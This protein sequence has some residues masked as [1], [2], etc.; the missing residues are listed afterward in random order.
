MSGLCGW[1]AARDALSPTLLAE[2]AA[3]LPGTLTGMSTTAVDSDGNPGGDGM[4]GAAAVAG[5][6]SLYRHDGVIVAWCGQPLLGGAPLQAD[7]LVRRWRAQGPQACA[8]LSG[9][10][11]L[12]IL[13]E[14]SGEA[15]LAIDRSG[16]HGLHYRH[17]DGLFFASTADALRA[18]PAL[19]DK[20]GKLD[21]QAL[22]DYLYFHMVPAPAT[23]YQGQQRLLPGEYLYLR[24]GRL[25]RG[26]YWSL[27]FDETAHA[28]VSFASLKSEFLRILQASVRRASAG[29]GDG[30]RVGAFLSGGTDS[31]TLAGVLGQVSGQP[32]AT[33]SIGFDAPGYDEMDYA[34]IAAR[35]FGTDHHEYYV[36]PDDVVSA[37]PLIA[38]AFDQPF[39]NASAL[40]AY[41]CARMARAD[42]V[43]RLL[44][45]DGG[46]ELFGGNERY[47]RQAV[48]ERYD[49]LPALLRQ[50]VLEPLLFQLA[51]GSRI[52]LLCK[53]RSYIEQASLALPAR[54]ETYNLLQRYG[55]GTVL[56]P[57]FLDSIDAGAPLASLNQAY[58]RSDGHSQINRLLALDMKFTLADNDLPKVMTA[59]QL[60]GVDAAF[61]LLDDEMVAFAARLAPGQKLHG[62]RLRH[63]F[64]QALRDTLPRAILRKQKHGFGLPFGLWLQQHAGLRSLAFDSLSALKHRHIVR[65]HFIDDLQQRHVAEHPAYH[66]TMVWV[67]MML[68]QW[69]Q[70]HQHQQQ[71]DRPRQPAAPREAVVPL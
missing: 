2:M 26:S 46:D 14:T 45:G 59:C 31:S 17:A 27:A 16:I 5:M 66:G 32:A 55:H 63:F 7:Q 1:F 52:S 70:Q 35:H 33:Y 28:G 23:I 18:D 4:R 13:D 68:E 24:A 60:A 53:A 12:A 47:A 41:Y 3:A 48:F 39:G 36:T 38:A 15:L 65:A 29:V 30:D 51:A 44:G 20:L 57:S 40:P 43:T 58:W 8:S 9:P 54:L 19:L 61:P 49:K 10:F 64:K 56:E 42:G 25:H 21:P 50:A 71:P 6:A 62:T 69:L 37:V 34:R 11:A 67:L 22:H